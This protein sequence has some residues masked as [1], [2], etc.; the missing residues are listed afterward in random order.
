MASI[1]S[2]SSSSTPC[3]SLSSPWQMPAGPCQE[4]HALKM[5]NTL[6]PWQRICS[7]HNLTKLP[8]CMAGFTLQAPPPCLAVH[9]QRK[10]ANTR[11]KVH[12]L[13]AF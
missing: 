3:T 4:A 5:L 9:K 2:S 1:E 8:P 13:C 11:H 7:G 6:L 10:S 12:Q